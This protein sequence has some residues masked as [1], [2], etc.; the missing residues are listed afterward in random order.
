MS[1]EHEKLSSSL[2]D[3]LE[4][5]LF[6]SQERHV[7]RA[8][9][10]GEKLHVNRSSVT[11]ALQALARKGLVNYSPYDFITLTPTG[12][13]AATEVARRHLVLREFIE[14]VLQ[15]EGEEANTAACG[16]EHALSGVVLERLVSFMEY[17]NRCPG[18]LAR[19]E[20]AMGFYCVQRTAK[21][22]HACEK[23]AGRRHV[24][25]RL[26]AEERAQAKQQ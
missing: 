24:A 22:P 3:Y 26:K 25:T 6:L 21:T 1:S 8:K 15:V 5:I 14:K 20:P 11:S 18:S 10:I 9:Q 16:M 7:A 4:A 2:E 13:K 17:V 23:C 19:W 12:E